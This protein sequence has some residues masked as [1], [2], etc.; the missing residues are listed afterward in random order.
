MK[1]KQSKKVNYIFALATR[2]MICIVT[3]GCASNR[4][5]MVT[6]QTAGTP[7]K[8]SDV[9]VFFNFKEIGGPSPAD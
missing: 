5:S 6:G 9:R 7:V 4:V 2:L 3:S 1:F 8:A